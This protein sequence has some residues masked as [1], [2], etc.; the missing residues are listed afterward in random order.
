MWCDGYELTEICRGAWSENSPALET[1]TPT[2][3]LCLLSGYYGEG[4]NAIIVFA[5]CHL[6]DSS[7]E[8]YTY[9]M[10]NLFL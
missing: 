1:N 10:E 6:P 8:D 2:N 5:A 3:C 9:I 7:S 4:L